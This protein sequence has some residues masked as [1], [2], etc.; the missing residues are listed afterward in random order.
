MPMIN[1]LREVAVVMAV[2][3]GRLSGIVAALPGMDR[4]RR[5]D[6]ERPVLAPVP[7]VSTP[8]PAVETP[9]PAVPPV[10]D[11]DGWPVWRIPRQG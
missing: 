1:G 4:F 10:D 5:R 2:T 8:P 3:H 7:G 11:E 9:A 6:A